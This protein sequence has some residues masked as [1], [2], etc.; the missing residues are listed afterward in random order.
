GTAY[1]GAY[2][3]AYRMPNSNVSKVT[4]NGGSY[5]GTKPEYMLD[6]QPNT[7]WETNKYNDATFT[8]EVV[9]ELAQAEV[10]DRVAFLARDN[11][12][13]FPEAFEIYASETS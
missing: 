2:S 5:S 3:E 11:R 4:T 10:L 7:H 1:E 12:K 9:F 13:G 6:D 8:N